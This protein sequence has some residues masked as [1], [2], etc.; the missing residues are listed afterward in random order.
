MRDEPASNPIQEMIDIGRGA[1]A[2]FLAGYTFP[3]EVMIQTGHGRRYFFFGLVALPVLM[4]HMAYTGNPGPPQP[5]T[6]IE[7]QMPEFPRELPAERYA[8]GD[9]FRPS[10]GSRRVG[11]Y[12]V[13]VAVETPIEAS[14]PVPPDPR[15]DLGP[16]IVLFWS[17]LGFTALHRILTVRRDWLETEAV[18]S[19]YC[20][21]PLLCVLDRGRTPETSVKVFVQPLVVF[22]TGT[23]LHDWNI[24]LGSYLTIS[25]LA[26]FAKTMIGLR[27]LR[28]RRMELRDAEIEREQL[29]SAPA[30]RERPTFV[31]IPASPPRRDALDQAAIRA[32]LGPALRRLMSGE[33]EVRDGR[34]DRLGDGPAGVGSG[35]TGT[36]RDDR[37]LPGA[38]PGGPERGRDDPA[39]AGGA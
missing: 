5:P 12:A 8:R 14:P 6:V 32:R 28:E 24:P 19:W 18:H 39:A 26:L 30:P 9:R 11:P 22:V 31:R 29:S 2:L 33:K 38:D 37:G 16:M 27:T 34:E 36:R 21:Y 4:V 15:R 13:P 3:I 23:V 25:G 35:A 7:F 17:Y 1:F 10:A 20:G